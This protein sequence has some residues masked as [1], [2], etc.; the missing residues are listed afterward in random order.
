MMPANTLNENAVIGNDSEVLHDIH[1]KAKNIAIYHRAIESLKKG[2]GNAINQPI[3]FRASGTKEEITFSLNTYFTNELP[4][5]NDF[6]KDVLNLL[7]LFERVTRVSSF[8]VSL[9]TI[10]T[11]MCPRFHADNNQLRMLC[12]YSGP[13]TLWLPNDAVDRDAYLTGKGNRKI[14][15]D[16]SHAQQVD[17]G[18]VVILKGALY[19]G[20][21]PILHRSPDVQE[22]GKQRILLSIDANELLFS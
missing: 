11:T 22:D 9:A 8:R 3:E 21:T 20:A 6:L 15:A 1:L 5:K 10:S 16:E 12:T 2:I 18:D 17:T 19:P 13:G 7:G 4:K 14:L